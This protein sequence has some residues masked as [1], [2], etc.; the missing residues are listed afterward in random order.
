MVHSEFFT[1]WKRGYPRRG[2]IF[3]EAYV[4][5]VVFIVTSFKPLAGPQ[6]WQLI[7][8]SYYLLS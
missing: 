8:P 6:L 3:E 4:F 5:V 2:N 1:E 7:C